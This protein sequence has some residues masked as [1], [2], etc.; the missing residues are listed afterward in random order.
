[1]GEMWGSEGTPTNWSCLAGLKDGDSTNLVCQV[2]CKETDSNDLFVVLYPCKTSARIVGYG[3]LKVETHSVTF[4][5]VVFHGDGHRPTFEFLGNS[6]AIEHSV[7]QSSDFYNMVEVCSGLG[8]ATTGFERLKIFTQVAC[9]LRPKLATAFAN[10]HPSSRVVVGDCSHQSTIRAV[11]EASEHPAIL[12]SGFNCQPYSRGG[13]QKGAEDSRSAS[14]KGVLNLGHLLRCPVLIL[15]CVV[16]ASSNRHVRRELTDFSKQMGFCLSE[17]VLQLEHIWPSRRDRWWVVLT[18]CSLGHV[19]LK[20]FPLSHVTP[21]VKDVLA[22]PMKLDQNELEQLLLTPREHEAFM[23]F[24]PCLSKL[25]LNPAGLCPTALHSWGSQVTGCFCDCRQGGLSSVALETKGIFG[26]LLPAPGVVTIKGV[27]HQSLRHPHPTEVALLTGMIPCNWQDPLRLFL[28]GLGQQASAIHA[29]WVA[30]H[31]MWHIET[32]FVGQSAIRPRLVLETYLDEL[33]SWSHR[34]LECES[35]ISLTG[36]PIVQ[37]PSAVD[38]VDIAVV[39]Q[40][41]PHDHG[42][43]EISDVV[44]QANLIRSELAELGCIIWRDDDKSVQTLKL[45]SVD[46]TVHDLLAAEVELYPLTSI[47][48]V[49]LETG[50]AMALED[51]LLNRCI[52]LKMLGCVESPLDLSMSKDVEM[53]LCP[54]VTNVGL[55]PLTDAVAPVV[56]EE[57]SPTIPFVVALPGKEE[58]GLDSSSG[59]PEVVENV[60]KGSVVRVGQ[61]TSNPVVGVTDVASDPLVALT[62]E[63][64]LSIPP[65]GISSLSALSPLIAP[66]V[67]SDVRLQIIQAQQ[68]AWADDEIRWHLHQLV[69]ASNKPA[70]VVLDPLLASEVARRPCPKLIFQWFS[71]L[72]FMPRMIVT[73]LNVSGHW[74]PFTWTWN[75]NCLTALSWDLPSSMP[76]LGHLH[77][78][79]AK[80]VGARTFITNIHHR[81]FAADQGC[82]VCAIRFVDWVLR[83]K[84]LPG[85]LAEV[86][87]LH[88][89][90][91]DLFVQAVASISHV[92]R[93]WLWGLGLDHNVHVRLSDLLRQHGVPHSELDDRMFSITQGIGLSAL[94]GALLGSSPWRSL[95]ALANNARTAVQ[96]V[97]P[98]ELRKVVQDKAKQGVGSSKKKSKQSGGQHKPAPPHPLSIDPSKLTFDHGAFV[99]GDGKPL[100]QLRA[101]DLGPLA[102]GVAIVAFSEV[103]PFLE[104]GTP[105]SQNALGAFVINTDDSQLVTKLS[106]EQCRVALRC[107]VNG[108]PMLVH[109]FLIQLG[110]SLVHQARAKHVAEVSD[111]QAACAKLTLYRDSITGSWDDVTKG[112]FKFILA[113]LPSLQVCDLPSDECRCPKWHQ[114][115]PSQV[116]DPSA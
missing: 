61:H 8:V 30:S 72:P 27:D 102:S 75:E 9:E 12:F 71:G 116:R 19:Q 41:K 113:M 57:V 82:G 33:R 66:T 49:D 98:D 51:K 3:P 95:K 1:M 31:V 64:L 101:P 16:E 34:F 78:S 46:V 39:E 14:L 73:A 52:Q 24:Q 70:V 86:Q 23:D 115:T 99:D 25:F 60:E 74:I 69:A 107:T 93:P 67:A 97:L 37:K 38:D 65:P 28:A 112:P 76:R 77:D 47:E 45:G 7:F 48:V 106:W 79:L 29:L 63:Q 13:S 6:L 35:G 103:S 15:E 42:L 32:C 68:A 53:P 84:M 83:L 108:E 40:V 18:D 59:C 81:Q 10:L 88:Q 44:L 26:I 111:V 114:S 89:C 2:A 100:E 85:N 55:H 56:D 58:M 21:Q 90:A 92:S 17:I 50:L 5:D 105:V 87:Q 104:A 36:L 109:G 96:L 110:E 11:V 22:R 94:Q 80:A 20:P 54:A 91:R 43:N 4:L 62:V